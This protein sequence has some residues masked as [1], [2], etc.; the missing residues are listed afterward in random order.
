MCKGRRAKYKKSHSKQPIKHVY[1]D[2][3]ALSTSDIAQD[4]VY[5]VL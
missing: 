5:K 3:V 4:F 2:S 1:I